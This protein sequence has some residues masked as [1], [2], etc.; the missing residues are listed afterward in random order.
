MLLC[1]WPRR[2]ISCL[3]MVEDRTSSRHDLNCWLGG[4]CKASAQE[5]KTNGRKREHLLTSCH[6]NTPEVSLTRRLTYAS[7]DSLKMVTLAF[8]FYH[9]K[10]S[11]KTD[12]K[13]KLF[14]CISYKYWHRINV[15]QVI[16][17]PILIDGAYS[18]EF[19]HLWAFV[20]LFCCFTSRSTAMFMMGWS[21]H[22]HVTTFFSGQAWTNG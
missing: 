16:Y 2:F 13:S 21:V 22:L 14:P 19:I 18:G 1:H 5:N 11:H 20:C 6:K 17:Q 12:C 3:V 15:N 10:L 7:T 4:T 9:E 8:T